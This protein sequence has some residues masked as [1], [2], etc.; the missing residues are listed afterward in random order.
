MNQIQYEYYGV[1]IYVYIEDIVLY[2]SSAIQQPRAFF[3][4]GDLSCFF[5]LVILFGGIRNNAS[6]TA[7]YIKHIIEFL[8]N[9]KLNFLFLVQY[10]RIHILSLSNTQV[11]L[12]LFNINV[13]AFT[14]YHCQQGCRSTTW[15][16][17]VVELSTDKFSSYLNSSPLNVFSLTSWDKYDFFEV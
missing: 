16:H 14:S 5:V 1:N 2:T 12:Y 17:L 9:Q 4:P 10:E 13:E 15:K 8:K 7:T 6:I 3:E 11:L